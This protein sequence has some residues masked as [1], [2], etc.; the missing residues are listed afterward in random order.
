MKAYW[1]QCLICLIQ[2]YSRNIAESMVRSSQTDVL[3][4]RSLLT[5]YLFTDSTYSIQ[6]FLQCKLQCFL[7]SLLSSVSFYLHPAMGLENES[8]VKCFLHVHK[9]TTIGCVHLGI[10]QHWRFKKQKSH[11]AAFS[12]PRMKKKWYNLMSNLH[13]NLIQHP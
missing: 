12:K 3:F 9:Y 13:T 6:Y 11:D 2:P 1:A 8:C 5:I 10:N 4:Y 7:K